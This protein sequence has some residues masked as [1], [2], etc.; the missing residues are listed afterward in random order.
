MNFARAFKEKQIIYLINSSGRLPKYFWT[1]T[2]DSQN[3][4]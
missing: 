4:F 3:Y 1:S 2:H